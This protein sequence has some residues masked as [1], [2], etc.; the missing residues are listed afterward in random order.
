MYVSE[1]VNCWYFG[2]KKRAKNKEFNL[3]QKEK[4]GC[5][6]FLIVLKKKYGGKV[7]FKNFPGSN[8]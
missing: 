4:K 1:Y 6:K 3:L 7:L 2:E 5:P 8:S